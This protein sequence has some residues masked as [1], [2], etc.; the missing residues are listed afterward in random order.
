M[1][2]ETYKEI[3]DTVNESNKYLRNLLAKNLPYLQDELILALP[4]VKLLRDSF[5]N[6]DTISGYNYALSDCI[7]AINSFFD[8][9]E[10]DPKRP[11]TD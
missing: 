8:D 10:N 5:D 1:K 7:N 2:K 4:K 9:V 11:D 3:C 6:K